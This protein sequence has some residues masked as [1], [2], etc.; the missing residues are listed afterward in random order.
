MDKDRELLPEDGFEIENRIFKLIFDTNERPRY[1]SEVNK[2]FADL[3]GVDRVANAFIDNSSAAMNQRALFY[4]VA[5]P[6]RLYSMLVEKNRDGSC[7][8]KIFRIMVKL[9]STIASSSRISRDDKSS[10]YEKYEDLLNILREEY[11]IESILSI[12]SIS[13]PL[14]AAKKI[15]KD[16]GDNYDYD[17][18][19][20]Y[21]YGGYG[22]YGRFKSTNYSD[23]DSEGYNDYNDSYFNR[24]I[25]GTSFE[26]EP[27]R[28][29]GSNRKR[30]YSSSYDDDDDDRDHAVD[31]KE[32]SS[33]IN[34]DDMMCEMTDQLK[35]LATAVVE[36]Q[37]KV[38]NP[39]SGSVKVIE[40]E[41][42]F[43]PHQR[44]DETSKLIMTK[45]SQAIGAINALNKNSKSMQNAIDDLTSHVAGLEDDLYGDDDGTV[46]TNGE[47]VD[48]DAII[49]NSYN[50]DDSNDN[51]NPT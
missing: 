50:A 37:K 41:P 22:N 6:K 3:F 27:G 34:S 15:I 20:G 45:L 29:K 30:K 21:G 51:S 24:I 4:R 36:L 38:D 10:Y 14:K 18:Y 1:R 19:G 49:A 2:I 8:F 16:R 12:E 46:V 5:N 11:D 25:K 42:E 40:A 33:G 13:N 32:E 44:S 31:S 39:S 43:T 26:R 28:K 17:F 35:T 48:I 23:D 7:D 47:N 9:L